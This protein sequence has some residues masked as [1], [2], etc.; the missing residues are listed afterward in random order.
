MIAFVG[1]NRGKVLALTFVSCLIVIVLRSCTSSQ[2]SAVNKPLYEG[3]SRSEILNKCATCHPHEHE[4]EKMG[5]HAY[6]YTA[7]MQHKKEVND[8]AFHEKPYSDFVN[9]SLNSMCVNCHA[10]KNLFEENY[11]GL[12][13]VAN[14]DSIA[15]FHP[16]VY[17]NP[18]ARTDSTTWATGVDCI[19]CHYAG[20]HVV[21]GSSFVELPENRKMKDYCFPVG[22]KF[23]NSD[24]LCASCHTDPCKNLKEFVQAKLITPKTTC[25]TCHQEY[26]NGNGTHYYY[27]R[28]DAI[29][30]KS[31]LYNEA[32]FSGLSA[33]LE[34][35]R[36][37]IVWVNN[38][39]PHEISKCREYVTTIEIK[40]A[41]GK[42]YTGKTI[43]LNRKKDHSVDMAE[44]FVGYC[45]PGISGHE[46]T[47]FT[48][49]IRENISIPKGIKLPL[50]ITVSALNKAQ[51]WVSDSLG[52]P[53]TVKTISLPS[54]GVVDP[55]KKLRSSAN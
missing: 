16:N 34:K 28:H 55:H 52:I 29:Q 19:T 36:V 54:S 23:L 46:F 49:T 44:H 18:S 1:F 53:M 32:L 7:L 12:E 45:L 22:S 11:K 30:N 13:Q 51:Y 33:T 15:S 9:K 43:H 2:N 20:T 6:A 39:I 42:K 3:F 27:W 47:P 8:P 25:N 17:N 26:K 24:L 10:S 14:L 4:N 37:A 48:D 31:T 40:D 21:A 50:T 38:N 5:P 41:N 35:D